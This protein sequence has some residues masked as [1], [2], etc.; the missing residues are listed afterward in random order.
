LALAALAVFL[1]VPGGPRTDNYQTVALMEARSGAPL[2][3]AAA[4]SPL[5]L[6]ADLRG[7]EA[8]M[9]VL[10]QVVDRDGRVVESR[11][12]NQAGL[13]AV[14]PLK[15]GLAAGDYW[16]RVSPAANPAGLLREYA[17]KVR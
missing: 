14:W 7:L 3:A 8:P 10:L 6:R 2:A 4:E 16:V 9:P 1:L 12:W 5:L 11:E 13:E 15:T 17:L